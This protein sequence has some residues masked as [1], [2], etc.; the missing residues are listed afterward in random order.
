MT[1]A[2][3]ALEQ[4]IK[5]AVEKSGGELASSQVEP[6]NPDAKDGFVKLTA[7]V[8]IDQAG[9]Q[10][11]LYEIESETPYLFVDKLSVQSPEDFGE[12]ETGRFRVTLAVLGQW[13]PSE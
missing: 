7:N 12:P 9:L 4:R 3:A 1:I 2:A 6:N 11:L 10:T 5:E 8:E 13:R